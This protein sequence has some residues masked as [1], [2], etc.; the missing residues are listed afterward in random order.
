MTSTKA[1]HRNR[2]RAE[3]KTIRA[4]GKRVID[5]IIEIGRLLTEAK[6]IAGHGNWLP[7]WMGIRVDRRHCLNYMRCHEMAKSRKFRDLNLPGRG[8]YLLAAPSTPEETREAVIARA[9]SGERLSVEDVRVV[10]ERTSTKAKADRAA[11]KQPK[12]MPD[13]RAA[14]DRTEGLIAGHDEFCLDT[15]TDSRGRK[16]QAHKPKKHPPALRSHTTEAP[17]TAEHA[18]QKLRDQIE[19]AVKTAIGVSP[20][21]PIIDTIFDIAADFAERNGDAK[22]FVLRVRR[23]IDSM[24]PPA[25]S[26]APAM[27]SEGD[28]RV[29]P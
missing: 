1:R 14:A 6:Q 10:I 19:A 13:V 22:K 16:Q 26:M 2:P 7:G 15:R 9:E 17:V 29:T 4:L 5:D 18:V 28:E 8:L 24:E 3:A 27:A 11:V 12:P 20:M 23:R 21:Q 25:T